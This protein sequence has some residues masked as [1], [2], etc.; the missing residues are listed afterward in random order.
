MTDR[1]LRFVLAGLLYLPV[2]VVEAKMTGIDQPDY[3]LLGAMTFTSFV[4]VNLASI[5]GK[6]AE[7]E[8][9]YDLGLEKGRT[10]IEAAFDGK[11]T[12]KNNAKSP[13]VWNS[14]S[15]PTVDFVLGRAYQVAQSEA[16]RKLNLEHMKLSARDVFHE[17]NCG[18]IGQ[19]AQ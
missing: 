1:L 17:M 5:A 15:G 7:A 13:I 19:G 3:G 8:R 9:L 4:C 11:L 2:P 16:R 10:Y 12:E 18:L 6:N 14:L